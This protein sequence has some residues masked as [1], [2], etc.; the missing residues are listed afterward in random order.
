MTRSISRRLERLEAHADTA[1]AEPHTLVFVDMN[2]RVSRTCTWENGQMVWTQFDPSRD[3]A[4]FEP[5]G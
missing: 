5:M 3:A 2:K 4:E 1:H